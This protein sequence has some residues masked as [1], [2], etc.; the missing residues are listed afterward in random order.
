MI[1]PPPPALKPLPRADLTSPPE[2]AEDKRLPLF[3]HAYMCVCAYTRILYF[4]LISIENY[5]PHPP[6]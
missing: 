6:A 5:P 2:D 4:Q 1:L 3:S